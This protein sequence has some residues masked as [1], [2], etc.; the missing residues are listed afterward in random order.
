[1][2]IKVIAV[3]RTTSCEGIRRSK[4]SMSFFPDNVDLIDCSKMASV[5]VFIPPPV[6]PGEAPININNVIP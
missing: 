3:A 5:V 1:M 2:E 6:E 4:N